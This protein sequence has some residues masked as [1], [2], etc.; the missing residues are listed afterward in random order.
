ML[1][2]LVFLL[3]A[4]LVWAQSSEQAIRRVLDDQAQAWN[5]G[6]IDAFMNGYEN[7]PNTV[8]IGKKVQRGYEAVRQ[9]Y[10]DQYPTS[11]KMGR[12]TFSNLSVELFSPDYAAVTGAFQLLRAESAGGNISGV[13]SLLFRRTPAGWKIILDHTS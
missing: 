8:F 9:R 12:L 4:S 2:T 10:H 1:R 5:R 6:D 7:S 11:E 3:V 13:F